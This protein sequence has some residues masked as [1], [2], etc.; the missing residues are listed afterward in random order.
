MLSILEHLFAEG[1]SVF[2]NE[3]II[4]VYK[5][6]LAYQEFCHGATAALPTAI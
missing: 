3:R 5:K 4:F 1:L 2:G 6:P